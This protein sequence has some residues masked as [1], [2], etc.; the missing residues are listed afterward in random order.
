MKKF[1]IVLLLFLLTIVLIITSACSNNSQVISY[2][3]LQRVK[4]CHK[5]SDKITKKLAIAAIRVRVP[6]YPE[7][8]ICVG[9][10][11]TE[12]NVDYNYGR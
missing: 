8:G 1:S 3:H 6:D 5:T 11:Y 12:T 2:V 4:Y 9:L 7:E 10:T